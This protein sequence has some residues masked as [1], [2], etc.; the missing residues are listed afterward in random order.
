LKPGLVAL[1]AAIVGGII[2]GIV[3][4]PPRASAS[5]VQEFFNDYFGRVTHASQRWELY[6]QDLTKSYRQIPNNSFTNYNKWWAS[7]KYVEVDNVQSTTGNKLAFTVWLTFYF[8]D[9]ETSEPEAVTYSLICNGP[10]A[11]MVARVPTFG[12]PVGWLQIENGLECPPS[13]P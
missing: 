7:I 1:S 13:N 5:N 3:A 2:A 4:A 6:R 11:P 8:R 9:G 10:L 12:C